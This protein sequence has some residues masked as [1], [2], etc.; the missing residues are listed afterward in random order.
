M[1]LY[2]LEQ[3]VGREEPNILLEVTSS[4]HEIE[5]SYV[6]KV[7]SDSGN[8]EQYVIMVFEEGEYSKCIT[9]VSSMRSAVYAALPKNPCMFGHKKVYVKGISYCLACGA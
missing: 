7:E 9:D 1:I 8:Y 2:S 4:R 3:I 5:R 6:E